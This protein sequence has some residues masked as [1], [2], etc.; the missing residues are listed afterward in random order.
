VDEIAER[1]GAV[2]EALD[3]ADASLARA[4]ERNVPRTRLPSAIAR[5][6]P[7]GP[8]VL[9]AYN[10]LFVAQLE[11]AADQNDALVA[12]VN[13]LREVVRAQRALERESEP[14]RP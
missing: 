9:R 5:L 6:G 1:L 2:T 8:V 14:P 10:A 13:A 7:L 3:A 4:R 12:V 11:V